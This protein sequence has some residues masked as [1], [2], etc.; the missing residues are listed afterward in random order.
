MRYLL[1]LIVVFSCLLLSGQMKVDTVYVDENFEKTFKEDA[2]FYRSISL[3]T[4]AKLYVVKDYTMKDTLYRVS[5]YA[6]SRLKKRQGSSTTYYPNGSVY[7]KENFEA[8]NPD[9]L[10]LEYFKSGST[11]LERSYVNNQRKGLKQYYPDGKLKRIEQYDGWKFISG[12]CYTNLGKDSTFSM[13]EQMPEY[14]GG[15]PA[16]A[17]FLSNNIQYPED[18][19]RKGISGRVYI[20]FIVSSTGELT[21]IKC[22]HGIGGGCDEE[23]I[24]V[25]KMMPKWIPGKEDGVPISIYFNCPIV[26]TLQCR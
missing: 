13:Y 22:V 14:P 18:A 7:R 20:Q 6:D 2:K 24:R 5:T 15:Q 16:L 12:N 21:R 26:Y 25:V 19:K 1:S 4:T 3:D 8:N 9:G 10:Q 17:K 11:K 23:S